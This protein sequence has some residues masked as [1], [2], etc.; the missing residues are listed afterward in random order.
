MGRVTETS[1]WYENGKLKGATGKMFFVK[2]KEENKD[3]GIDLLFTSS[4]KRR[5]Q[6]S[7]TGR[8]KIATNATLKT[9]NS[10]IEKERSRLA[11]QIK[12]L[13]RLRKARPIIV[14]IATIA[15]VIA[16]II[17]AIMGVLKIYG[18]TTTVGA[19]LIATTIYIAA[20]ALL[21]TIFG[22]ITHSCCKR[23][24]RKCLTNQKNAL[25]ELKDLEKAKSMIE[26]II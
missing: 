19:T 5:E 25:S 20:G 23:E 2:D 11:Y 8:I 14:T 18:P 22:K 26:S 10:R 15:W 1:Y 12:K 16:G 21:G 6:L 4:I 7:R 9:L 13:G 24:Y 3:E 17:A